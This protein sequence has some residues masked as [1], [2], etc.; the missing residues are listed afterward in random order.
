MTSQSTCAHLWA[1]NLSNFWTLVKPY[2]G[3]LAFTFLVAPAPSVALVMTFSGNRCE[4][5]YQNIPTSFHSVFLKGLLDG[6][7]NPPGAISILDRDLLGPLGEIYDLSTDLSS[8]KVEKVEVLERK[9]KL[10]DKS[11]EA[12]RRAR[13]SI[14]TAKEVS[15]LLAKVLNVENLD[16]Q[17]V[18][19]RFKNWRVEDGIESKLERAI[20][21]RMM[22]LYVE[23]A[24]WTYR[25]SGLE[26]NETSISMTML[27]EM[28]MY[29]KSGKGFTFFL[30]FDKSIWEKIILTLRDPIALFKSAQ[31]AELKDLVLA[32]LAKSDMPLLPFAGLF[33]ATDMFRENT[34]SELKRYFSNKD[35]DPLNLA[36]P[37]S[38][39]EFILRHRMI[40]RAV[41]HMPKGAPLEI[42]A[43]TLVHARAYKKLGFKQSKI[44]RNEK[45]P[46]VQIYLLEAKR[47][48]VLE[49][50]DSLLNPKS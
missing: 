32:S 15:E 17:T 27:D 34:P 5:F 45:Y 20:R 40:Y 3:A 35:E 6:I 48:D 49:K 43:H 4:W 22:S 28:A 46:E 36:D 42:H 50:I 8:N 14:I 39:D 26:K 41:E 29:L 38:K 33:I 47:E 16:D 21:H 31:S 25:L 44:I 10:K 11:Q 19:I 9:I 30:S 12:I 1:P 13:N 7:E 18:L 37:A 24:N 23:M 2:F